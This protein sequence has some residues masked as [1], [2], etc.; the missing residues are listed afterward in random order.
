MILGAN[1]TITTYRLQDTS[2]V[3]SYGGTAIVSAAEAFIESPSPDVGAVLGEQAGYETFFCYVEPG[4]YRVTDKVVDASGAVY[5]IAG[6]ERHENNTDTDDLYMLR[7]NK[8]LTQY[9]G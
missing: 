6:I 8:A 2:D 4:N 5:S 1:T 7:L 9:N 3:T